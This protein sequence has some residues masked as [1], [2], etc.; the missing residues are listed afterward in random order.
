M[1][2][3]DPPEVRSRFETELP[4]VDAVV[5]QV[6]GS[7]G[8]V[9]PHDELVSFGREGL[10]EAARRYD[11]ERGVPF[12]RFA[13]YRIK[14]A[15]FDGMRRHAE[16]PRRTHEKVRALRAATAAAEGMCE[17]TAAAVA[18]GLHGTGADQRLADQL[19]TLATAMAI[20]FGSHLAL[21]DSG[22]MTIVDEADNPEDQ[23]ERAE[24]TRIVQSE[25]ARLPEVEA[26]L[27]RRHILGEQSLEKAA[28]GVGLS[29]SW[30][31]RVL[32]RGM[33]TLTRRLQA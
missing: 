22:T 7:V 9:L 30:A 13:H 27:I 6:R 3:L 20:G 12:R 15:V 23:L 11:P 19:A 8:E 28:A 29:K 26:T 25:L 18:A 32:A 16:L 21:D 10:L 17:D 31:S 24:L 4:L 14:G 2:S 5:R 1:S 33:A